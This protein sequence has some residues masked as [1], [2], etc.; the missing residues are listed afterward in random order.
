MRH[1]DYTFNTPLAFLCTSTETHITELRVNCK[2]TGRVSRVHS[3][4]LWPF[5]VDILEQSYMS[6][7]L[8]WAFTVYTHGVCLSSYTQSS[9]KTVARGQYLSRSGS[10]D[11]AVLQLCAQLKREQHNPSPILF[12]SA[13]CSSIENSN[14]FF[15]FAA[16]KRLNTPYRAFNPSVIMRQPCAAHTIILPHPSERA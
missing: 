5:T 8:H 11:S 2:T 14:P 7:V 3:V 9:V 4:W 15:W 6:P 13:V 10:V 12:V 16:G 1:H